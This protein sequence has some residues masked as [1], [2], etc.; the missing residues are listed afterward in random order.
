MRQYAALSVQLRDFEGAAAT[1]ERLVDLEPTNSP[2]RL[3]LAIAYFALGNYDLAEYHMAAAQASG[4]LSAE[5]LAEVVRYRTEAAENDAPSRIKGRVSLGQ[6]F[7]DEAAEQGLFASGKL[8]WRLD[9]GGANADDFLLEMAFSS[10]QPGDDS[11]NDRLTASLRAGPEFRLTGDAYGPRLQPYVELQTLHDN[12]AVFGDFNSWAL[13]LAYQNPISA[14]WTV[15]SD[16]SYGEATE[17]DLNGEDFTFTE[18]ELGATW[19]PSRE[20]RLRAT[21]A[22]F[23]QEG[24]FETDRDGHSF[25]L[26][27]QHTF[28]PGFEGLPRRWVVGGFG[29]VEQTHVDY[30]GF[31]EEDVK[32]RAFGLWL[33]AFVT[34]DIFIETRATQI[35]RKTGDDFFTFKE[36]ET[37]MS[38]QLGW[39]F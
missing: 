31:F 1:L 16:L 28:D 24:E 36:K 30:S 33:S 22:V 5:D 14:S 37:I 38:I 29:E 4:G 20:T 3:E 21:L 17:D 15:Y 13:G 8:E 11:V 2:A 39:E 35:N 23:R 27:A 18:A 6:A 12:E 7:T 26:A 32:E 34:E 9:M 25:R 10:F 19:R